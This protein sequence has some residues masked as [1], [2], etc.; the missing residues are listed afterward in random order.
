MRS[1]ENFRA[2]P[3]LSS[4]EAPAWVTLGTELLETVGIRRPLAISE[5]DLVRG[6][7]EKG[8]TPDILRGVFHTV[9]GR[10]NCPANP[11]LSYFDGAVL[12]MLGAGKRTPVAASSPHSTPAAGVEAPTQEAREGSEGPRPPSN[13]SRTS[14]TK[15]RWSRRGPKSGRV[16]NEV[17]DAEYR[18]WLRPMTLRGI[19]GDEVLVSLPGSFVR[20]WVRD[21]HGVG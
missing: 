11:A 8:A 4:A 21:H 12:D 3:A 6:W 20:D 13:G 17:G 2:N 14:L 1:D 19:D 5:A 15:M 10:E 7:L 9:L 16:T 18:N